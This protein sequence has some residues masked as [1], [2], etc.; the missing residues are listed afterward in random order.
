MQRW[1]ERFVRER[2]LIPPMPMEELREH[3][4]AFLRQYRIDEIY[5]HY[6]AVL[7]NNEAWRDTL[8][9]IPYERRLLLLPKCLRNESGCPASIDEFGLLC[10]QCGLC[11]IQDLEEEAQ[12]LGYAVLVA[13]GSAMVSNIIQNKKIDAIV[14]VSCLNVLERSFPYMEAA[15]IP[16]IAIPMLQD[17]CADCTVDMDWVWDVIH[18]T[19]EDKTQRLDL[20]AIKE[21][22]H[23]WFTSDSL[24]TIMGSTTNET[25]RVA[26]EW[27]LD[28]GKRWRPYLTVSAYQALQGDFDA[29]YPNDLRKIAIAVECFHKASLIHDDIEDGDAFR[30]CKETLHVKY[31]VPIA[32]NAGDFLVGEGYRLL[33]ECHDRSDATALMIRVAAQG[34]RQ[35]C[36]GQGMEL[37]WSRNPK[38]LSSADVIEIFRQK[39]APAF[40]VALRLGA[41]YAGAHEEIDDVLCRYSEALGVAY[42]IRDDLDDWL[43]SDVLHIRPSLVLAMAYEQARDDIKELIQSVWRSE[44]NPNDSK[45][46][47]QDFVIRSKINLQ[48]QRLKETYKEEAVH[49]LRA[50]NHPGL[51]GL[52]R[53]VAAKIFNEIQIEGWCSEFETRNATSG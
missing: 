16:G 50:L 49:A 31:G 34:H 2:N 48:A 20:E 32:L 41:I 15:A 8:A 33:A 25:E 43:G 4:N 7:I 17:D 22:V 35:L 14:G 47:I 24:N 9:S 29:P 38:P 12:R 52:L 3:A 23:S 46:R 10:R 28:N 37:N 13:E 26:R 53:R 39:T 40:E 27:M 36:M 11:S 19:S 45:D 42:Q 51:K 21:E 44:I 1:I 5:Q 6:T 30:Y 18:L